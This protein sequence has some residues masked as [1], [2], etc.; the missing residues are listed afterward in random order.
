MVLPPIAFRSFAS[1]YTAPE[2]SEGFEDIT[3]INFK[4]GDI[5]VNESKE[6]PAN[7]QR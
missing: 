5:A 3:T 7:A 6:K 4:V 1:N 2:L